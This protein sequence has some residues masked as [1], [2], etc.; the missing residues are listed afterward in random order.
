L[1]LVEHVDDAFHTPGQPHRDGLLSPIGDP[2]LK[3][4][5]A[6]LDPDVESV[7]GEA[8]PVS[9]QDLFHVGPDLRVGPEVRT[10]QVAPGD[11]PHHDALSKDRGPLDLVALEHPC[12]LG[13]R[14]LL[15]QG[16][17]R[18]GHHV[19]DPSDASAG[20]PLP[21]GLEV[22]LG[23]DPQG[24]ALGVGHRH[25][26][27]PVADQDRGHLL[28]G[29]LGPDRDQPGAHHVSYVHGSHLSVVNSGS[30]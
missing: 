10:E 7:A 9:Q 18:S 30:R 14:V 5:D 28:E 22:G 27:D 12:R 24:V 13:H 1:E 25:P 6:T 2:T 8:K 15:G 26:A 3:A 21:G 17:H 4:D 19:G 20:S 11:H 29:L 16:D 23:H